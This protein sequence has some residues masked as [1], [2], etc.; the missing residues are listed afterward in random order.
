MTAV[1]LESVFRRCEY[2]HGLSF[3]ENDEPQKLSFRTA[4][5]RIELW[6]PVRKRWKKATPEEVVRQCFV[7]WIQETLKYPLSRIAVEERLQ[8]GSDAEKERI[9]IVVF[10][11]D[12]RADRFI[13]FELKKPDVK[14]GIDQLRSYLNWTGCFFGAWSNGNDYN[15]HL[16]EEDPE[17]R[18]APYRYRDIPRLPGFGQDVSDVLKPLSFA[19]LRPIHD[20]RSL[21]SRLEYD[22]LSNAGVT[23]FDELFKLFFAKLH[24][25]LRPRRREAGPVEFRVPVGDPEL[26]FTRVNGLFLA[27]KNRSN[28]DN[29]F[30]KGE[31]LKLTGDA[32]RLCASALEPFSLIK[33]DLEV[34]DA[35][36][37][38]GAGHQ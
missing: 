30:D 20:L 18:K 2:G 37:E 17:T 23:P 6:C 12:A 36:F 22:A 13:V 5:E 3:F 4:G 11:D 35:A 7:I 10:S 26:V 34:V 9:D 33:T 19:E 14:T 8:R 28:W 29:I 1:Y 24:D 25:E 27:A 21:V 38:I 15:F 16:R 31:E 32:L